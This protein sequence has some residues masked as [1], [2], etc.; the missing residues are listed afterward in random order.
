MLNQDM[1]AKVAKVTDAIQVETEGRGTRDHGLV[2]RY[3]TTRKKFDGE[4]RSPAELWRK[5]GW[6]AVTFLT[7]VLAALAWSVYSDSKRLEALEMETRL[8]R[9]VLREKEQESRGFRET[10]ALIWAVP[11]TPAVSRLLARPL[12][13]RRRSG[14]GNRPLA[15][16][17]TTSSLFTDRYRTQ[18]L[19]PKRVLKAPNGAT[20]RSSSGSVNII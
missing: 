15:S 10:V 18:Q 12:T 19:P 6:R 13:I 7:G 1:A 11:P 4:G 3:S 14:P 16:R 2:R 5:R 17:M 20:R 8:L 9:S